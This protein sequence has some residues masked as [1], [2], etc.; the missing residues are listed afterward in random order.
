MSTRHWAAQVAGFTCATVRVP[1]DYRLPAGPTINLVVV[2]H[3]AAVPARRGVIFLNPGG[4]G[5]S[6]TLQFAGWIGRVPKT[7]L[8]DYDIISWDPRGVGESTAV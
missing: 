2:R 7:L 5:D 1:L 6:G 4:P 3:A 8:R